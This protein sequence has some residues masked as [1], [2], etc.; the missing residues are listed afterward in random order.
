M[1]LDQIAKELETMTKETQIEAPIANLKNGDHV[2]LHGKKGTVGTAGGYAAEDNED[3]I[4][5]VRHAIGHGHPVYWILQEAAV[6]SSDPGYFEREQKKWADAIFL[7]EGQR[8]WLE[9]RSF[10]VYYKGNYSDMGTFREG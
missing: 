3:P 8:V 4:D 7:E 10:R 6:L 2:M 5:S 1:G 9:G